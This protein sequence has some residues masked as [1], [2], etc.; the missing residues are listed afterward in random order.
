MS[1]KKITEYDIIKMSDKN[2]SPFKSL[3]NKIHE[4][5]KECVI[6]K[7]IKKIYEQQKEIA[8][9]KFQLENIIKHSLIIIKKCLQKKNLFP[10]K[11]ISL[12]YENDNHLCHERSIDNNMSSEF[13]PSMIRNAMSLTEEKK[14]QKSRINDKSHVDMNLKILK[15]YLNQNSKINPINKNNILFKY[16]E[17]LNSLNG[18]KYK[19]KTRNNLYNNSTF[20]SEKQNETFFIDKDNHRI[21]PINNSN[22][23]KIIN[24]S[25]FEKKD[26]SQ[27]IINKYRNTHVYAQ[28]SFFAENNIENGKEKNLYMNNNKGEN[29]IRLLKKSDINKISNI[30]RNTSKNIKAFNKINLLRNANNLSNNILNYYS[31]EK[32]GDKMKSIFSEKKNIFSHSYSKTNENEKL[33]NNNTLTNTHMSG[34]GKINEIILKMKE[35]K[36]SSPDVQNIPQKKH[37]VKKK[38]NIFE[39]SKSNIPNCSSISERFSDS[40][41]N[42]NNGNKKN[43][44][45]KRKKN[46]KI[47]FDN[48]K[49]ESI[50]N[51]KEINYGD[52][53]YD[54]SLETIYNPTFT[55]FLNRKARDENGESVK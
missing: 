31:T 10:E 24:I 9:L 43:G 45:E 18:M 28:H 37:K 6:N 52:D 20:F 4:E 39:T 22:L 27:D 30:K 55:S 35:I 42:L 14:T 38:I 15:K 1:L 19:N 25:S 44:K 36:K 17:S 51:I 46:I 3:K 32:S 47:H 21:E 53:K 16:R 12:S 41:R 11:Q 23:R 48:K 13:K 7:F 2:Y 50:I 8:E 26:K 40:K 49:V 5:I 34:I 54:N 33:G 29:R